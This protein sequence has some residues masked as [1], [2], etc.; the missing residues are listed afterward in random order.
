MLDSAGNDDPAFKEEQTPDL[1]EREQETLEASRGLL[2][3]LLANVQEAQA[4]AATVQPPNVSFGS[5]GWGF[6]MG[7]NTAPMSGFTFNISK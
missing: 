6:Q 1:L 5:Q 4:N 3:G 2:D 7:I